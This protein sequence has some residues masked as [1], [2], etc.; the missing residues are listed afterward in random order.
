MAQSE[1]VFDKVKRS[2]L[3]MASPFDAG[4]AKL[5][6]LVSMN[7]PPMMAR[8]DAAYDRASKILHDNIF[9]HTEPERLFLYSAIIKLLDDAMDNTRIILAPVKRGLKTPDREPLLDYLKLLR[10]TVSA[11]CTL[12]SHELLLSENEREMGAFLGSQIL[13]QFHASDE[14]FSDSE[15]NIYHCV[16]ELIDS[17]EPA[18][19][20]YREHRKR[21]FDKGDLDRYSKAF[22]EFETLYSKSGLL[23]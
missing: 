17:A 21:A 2:F 5:D 13:E 23:Q 18:I 7:Y 4:G 8:R 1:G 22:S 3:R 16:I 9:S 15:M 12:V 14:I 10:D 11:A 19:M 6:H 20:R